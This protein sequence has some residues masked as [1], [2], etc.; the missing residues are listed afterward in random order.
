MKLK[1]GEVYTVK[2][3]PKGEAPVIRQCSYY[4]FDL[5]KHIFKTVDDGYLYPPKVMAISSS[6]LK[7]RV[8]EGW[9]PPYVRNGMRPV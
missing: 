9:D 3:Y 2:R 5:G 1:I 7:E 8:S 6:R 4:G